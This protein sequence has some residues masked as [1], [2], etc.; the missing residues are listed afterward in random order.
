MSDD[1]VNGI[2]DSLDGYVRWEQ[3]CDLRRAVR[4]LHKREKY[5]LY[6]TYWAGLN[7]SE[8]AEIMGINSS[9]VNQI[10]TDAIRSLK[11]RMA[12]YDR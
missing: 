4:L 5:V 8:T 10:K 6:Y 1:F 2:A 3:S 9:R 7:Q 12:D 11:T